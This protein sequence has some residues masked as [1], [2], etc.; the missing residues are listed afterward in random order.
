MTLT[1]MTCRRFRVALSGSPAGGVFL[2]NTAGEM[3][4]WASAEGETEPG[5]LNVLG[6][7]R[8]KPLLEKL[9]NGQALPYFGASFQDVS[10]S[11]HEAGLPAGVYVLNVA[12]GGPAYDAGIQSGDIIVGYGGD[13]TTSRS[14]LEELLERT[15]AGAVVPV[16]VMRAGRE[17]YT[18]LSYE[19]TLR[20]R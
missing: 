12:A 10:P 19:V 2:V 16:K 13:V 15:E 8:F 6:I 7:S 18:E 11:M 9:S 3:V 17:G 14:Y 4:G 1:D 5:I 20:Q